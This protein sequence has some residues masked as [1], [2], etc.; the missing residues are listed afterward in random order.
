MTNSKRQAYLEILGR[1][2]NETHNQNRDIMTIT[3][4]MNSEEE[5]LNHIENS[6]KSAQWFMD[7][8]EIHWA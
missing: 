3:G 5:I 8:I 4:F 2:Q 6:T 7:A 1:V